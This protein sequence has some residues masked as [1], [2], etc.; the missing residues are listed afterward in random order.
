MRYTDVIL[1]NR[2]FKVN[3]KLEQFQ[4]RVARD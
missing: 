3:M 1:A 2:C 4:K